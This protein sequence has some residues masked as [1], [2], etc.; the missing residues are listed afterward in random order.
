MSVM[1]N[2][3]GLLVDT[4][5]RLFAAIDPQVNTHRFFGVAS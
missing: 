5:W 3:M 4:D 2:F 1:D